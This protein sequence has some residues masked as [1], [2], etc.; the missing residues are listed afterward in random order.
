MDS[1]PANPAVIADGLGMTFRAPVRPPGLRAALASVVYRRYR[2][3]EA[4]R[5]LTF[6]LCPGEIAGFLGPNGAGKSTTMKLLTGILHPTVGR[7]EV[8]GRVPWRRE[9]AL[10]R[11]IA[12]VRGGRPL[13]G[14]EELTVLDTFRF[15]RLLYEIPEPEFR[16]NL[17]ELTDLLGLAELNGRQVRALSLGERMRAG[18]AVALLHRPRVLFLDEPTIGLDVAAAATVRAFLAA[19]AV[20]T[21]ATVLLTSHHMPDVE[22]LCRRVLLI[23]R[24]RLRYDGE[25]AR[26]SAAL[27]PDQ[28]VRVTPVGRDGQDWSRFGEVQQ[29]GGAGAGSS[30]VLRVPRREVPRVVGELLARVPVAGLAVEEPPLDAVLARF[31]QRATP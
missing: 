27:T 12:L 9:R 3:I 1:V 5:E 31:H 13:G 15:Q 14:P 18:L 25:L 28:L 8:L 23:D 19:Y 29:D 11:R 6:E 21:S 22:A 7:A 30:V 17:G 26:L 4:V 24:G 2:T 20:Q 16:R 10:L